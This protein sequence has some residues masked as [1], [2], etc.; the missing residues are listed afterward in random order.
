MWHYLKNKRWKLWI[1]KALDCDTRQFLDWECGRRDKATLRELVYRQAQWDVKLYCTDHWA[2]YAS[3]LP[4]DR[5]V[6]SKAA[7]HDIER[8]HCRP[9]QRS[10]RF[11]RKSI[12]VSKSQQT[13]DL[14]MALFV[15]FWVNGDQNELLSLLD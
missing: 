1:W 2:V 15:T 4:Q 5:L 6:Q 12:I 3:V 13:V 9:R 8:N 10:G 14:T 11:K 7:T